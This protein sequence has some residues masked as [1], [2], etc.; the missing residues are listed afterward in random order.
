MVLPRRPWAAGRQPVAIDAAL[1][2]VVEGKD[3]A[4][5][6]EPCAFVAQ[7]R[8]RRARSAIDQVGA[9]AVA[10]HQHRHAR[11]HGAYS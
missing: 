4:E 8:E 9:Q 11:A 3:A 7:A 2:R 1:V 10:D 6:G 5:L